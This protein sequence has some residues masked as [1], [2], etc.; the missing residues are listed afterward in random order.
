ERLIT[1]GAI[2]GTAM[3]VLR[4]AL[5]PV[6]VWV[7]GLAERAEWGLL[8]LVSLPQP[9]EWLLGLLLLDYTIWVWHYLNHRVPFLWRF[10][11][12][13]HTDLDLDVSTAFRFHFGELL[14]SAFWRCG[15]V[16]LIGP[17]PLLVLVWEIVQEAATEFHHS[18]WT[19][20]IRV[21]RALNR[22][23]VTP[24][25]H[26]IHH[27]VVERETN[28]NWSVLFS[29]WDRLHRTARLDVPQDEIVIGVPAYRDPRDLTVPALLLM[30]FR[31]QPAYWRLPN[32]IPPER[33]V[34]GDTN[35]LAA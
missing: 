23:I 17:A 12:V 26:G 1:N 34:Q 27:S 22:I 35:R 10:H 4:L 30:P 31:S 18:N 24:R 9:L 16:V 3:L 32:G 14:L 21:E 13:H 5:I 7:A 33:D 8:N 19:L 20:P 15:Q 2:A 29:W 25:M 6:V 28:S 11:H